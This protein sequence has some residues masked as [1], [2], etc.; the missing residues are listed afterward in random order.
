MHGQTATFWAHNMVTAMG[1]I[2][3][4]RKVRFQ[5]TNCSSYLFQLLCH[6]SIYYKK[7]L[8]LNYRLEWCKSDSKSR[9]LN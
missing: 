6:N 5:I 7:T 8:G 3:C 4:E 9:S 1:I 2:V